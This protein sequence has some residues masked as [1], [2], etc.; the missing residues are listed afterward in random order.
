M[1]E[2]LIIAIIWGNVFIANA[3]LPPMPREKPPHRAH[4]QPLP[5][6]HPRHDDDKVLAGGILHA[7]GA[8]AGLVDHTV[9]G[10]ETVV[11][12]QPTTVVASQ[13]VVVQ[14]P[15]TVVAPQPIIKQQPTAVVAAQPAV[16]Q[17]ATVVENQS[18]VQQQVATAAGPV[19]VP[20]NNVVL[21]PVAPVQPVMTVA[22]P[23]EPALETVYIPATYVPPQSCLVKPVVIPM[24]PLRPW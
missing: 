1:K 24:R 23:G 6:P 8:V 16:V 5:K 21:R 3:A 12:Q 22:T 9:N 11:V 13:P 15:T 7:L 4:R 18:F 19:I 20:A 10:P 2:I 14:Q 17:Q